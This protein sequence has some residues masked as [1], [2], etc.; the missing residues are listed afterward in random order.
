MH[1]RHMPGQLGCGCS[2]GSAAAGA[3]GGGGSLGR[4]RRPCPRLPAGGSWT[5]CWVGK[6]RRW[7][8]SRPAERGVQGRAVRCEALQRRA[9]RRPPPHPPPHPSALHRAAPHSAARGRRGG[10]TSP[11]PPGGATGGP[12]PWLKCSERRQHG[13]QQHA[14]ARPEERGGRLGFR[15]GARS[16]TSGRT[17][18]HHAPL[19]ARRRGNSLTLCSVRRWSLLPGRG[20]RSGGASAGPAA[21]TFW[22]IHA[23]LR[24]CAEGLAWLGVLLEPCAFLHCGR[25]PR[26]LWWSIRSGSSS[27][28]SSLAA[29]VD[30]ARDAR[31]GGPNF[32]VGC[33]SNTVM[34]AAAAEAACYCAC[35]CCRTCC[36][37][38]S[39]P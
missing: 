22:G 23:A 2:W 36:R 31:F 38:C 9:C 16:P 21:L 4:V 15:R 30:R 37:T 18:R 39:R 11:S 10:A 7:R 17:V 6:R 34:A 35:C 3:A 28:G 13:S 29:E 8:S 1:A 25:M 19:P 5:R 32:M 12:G 14:A 27:S 24:R 20:W 33:R 26:D